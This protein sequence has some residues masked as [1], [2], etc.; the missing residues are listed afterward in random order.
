MGPVL[1]PGRHVL[2][3][4][5]I[6]LSFVLNLQLDW[7]V[8]GMASQFNF[9]NAGRVAPFG[10]PDPSRTLPTSASGSSVDANKVLISSPCSCGSTLV[11][12]LID[13]ST[14]ETCHDASIIDCHC[15]S[16]RRFHVS[17]FVRYLEVPENDVSISGDSV[18][19]FKDSCSE[20]G[21]VNRIYC[22]RCSTKL[23]TTVIDDGRKTDQ[24]PTMLINLGSI[25][26][27]TVPENIASH[28]ANT[29]P[30]IWKPN[31]EASWTRAVPL[32][33][34]RLM[35]QAEPKT[36]V[37][38]GGCTCGACQYEFKYY[39]PSE[40][41]HCYCNLCRQL[42]G[43]MFMS[44]VP[45]PESMQNF[46]WI[47]EG[48]VTK[49]NLGTPQRASVPDGPRQSTRPISEGEPQLVRYTDIGQRH[50]CAQ[51]GSILSI[52]YDSE[53]TMDDDAMIWL[54]A[55]GFDSVRFPFNVAPYL[56]RVLHIC[57]RFKPD[58]YVLP[59]DDMPQLDD[60][61]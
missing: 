23:L 49:V 12:F 60:A 26:S 54:A 30:N 32:D 34:D 29:L 13:K 39:S 8:S 40:L 15:V 45:V 1:W 58:W 44:W 52:L 51:C 50:A 9:R 17:A 41:Q 27:T 56:D 10:L 3:I 42:S 16:C 38:S 36:V 53:N 43:S 47:K 55:G 18:V 4:N 57:C 31:M 20:V 48:A 22:R 21:S 35:Q 25:D 28:W 61:S 46:R 33:D 6:T 5:Y 7:K 19:R 37:S 2:L 14:A 11:E 59:D 24:K